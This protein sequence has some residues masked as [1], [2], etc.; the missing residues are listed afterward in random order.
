M[1]TT[2]RIAIVTGANRGI[3]P[4]VC[5]QL[6][7]KGLE[8]ILT[9]RDQSKGQATANRLGVAYHPLEVT[10]PASIA[11]LKDWTLKTYGRL[12]V[13]V[14][15]AALNYDD[16]ASVMTSPVQ[17]YRDTLEANVYGP[18]LLCQTFI[19]L[20]IAQGY[21]RVVNVSSEMGQ[22]CQMGNAAPAYS[23][24]KTALNVLTRM[25]A[26]AAKNHN[27]LV[28][29]VSPGWVRTDMGGPHAPRSVKKGAQGIV[30]GALLPDGG[31]SGGFFQ[32]G[33]ALEW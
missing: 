29:S 28:N 4:E 9:S 18:L 10:D 2:R 21:G 32:D 31:P 14:N 12:D 25:F 22:L 3:G 20:M 1:N 11:A 33:E 5:R 8:V 7:E 6:K 26:A 16:H 19:P 30:W 17:T 27:V 13:L 15:N 24:S 23:L